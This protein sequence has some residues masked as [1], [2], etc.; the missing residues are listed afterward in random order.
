MDPVSALQSSDPAPAL[1]SSDPAPEASPFGAIL[2]ALDRTPYVV[3]IGLVL[4]AFD[5][6]L[7][8][9][10]AGGS[11]LARKCALV[12][13]SCTQVRKCV[14]APLGKSKMP[15]RTISVMGHSSP[16]EIEMAGRV[17]R[18]ASIA[19]VRACPALHSEQ[20]I[21][22]LRV[23]AASCVGHAEILETDQL[24]LS[25]LAG[26]YEHLALDGQ[27]RVAEKEHEKRGAPF[28]AS[29]R[30]EIMHPARQQPGAPL[31][32][33]LFLEGDALRGK[34]DFAQLGRLADQHHCVRRRQ[35][36]RKSESFGRLPLCLVGLL[37]YVHKAEEGTSIERAVP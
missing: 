16:A 35:Y 8:S 4:K 21:D 15:D 23:Q 26:L 7:S 20:V 25:V 1:Q 37:V 12:H 13:P 36:N 27:A 29:Y 11:L 34:V 31:F 6:A 17:D 22:L 19:L 10:G 3:A 33:V 5:R 14:L 24:A 18:L 32:S 28:D 2:G 9:G 30:R